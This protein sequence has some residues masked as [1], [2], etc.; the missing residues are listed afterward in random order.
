MKTL[1]LI[2]ARA[3]SKGL[4][5]KNVKNLGELPLIAY[6]ILFAKEV[7]THNDIVCISTNDPEV[8]DIA[9]KYNLPVPFVRPDALASDFAGS[10]EVIMH[11]LNHYDAL[12]INFDSVLLLQPTSPFRLVEDFNKMNAL[13][14]ADCDMVVSVCVSKNSPYFNLF[15]QD[16]Y[17]YLKKSKESD[18]IRRQDCPEVYA[19]NGSMY[20]ISVAAL[21]RT[22]FQ[23][24]TKII[25]SVMPEERSIDIDNMRDWKIAEY[26]LI[27]AKNENS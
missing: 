25:K 5:G 1:I 9:E 17:G 11:A 2:P 22:N 15:E 19:F 26:F 4:K 24:F 18:G 27:E 8:I 10:Y 14:T 12:D 7:A 21:K 16:Q 20:L 13:Y 6:S 23:G 3:G